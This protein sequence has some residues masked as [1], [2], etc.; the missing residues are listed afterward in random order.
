MTEQSG[1]KAMTEIRRL[2]LEAEAYTA[3]APEE[4]DFWAQERARAVAERGRQADPSACGTCKDRVAA[5]GQV[6]HDECAQRATLLPAP[7]APGYELIT[8]MTEDDVRALPARFHTP[9]FSELSTPNAW[10]CAVCWGDG[11]STAWPCPTAVKNGT[12]VFTPEHQAETGAKKQAAE[13]ERLRKERDGFRDQRNAVF[14][15]N[16]RLIGEVEA[17]GQ[18][19]IHAENQTRAVT[20]AA[21]EL[22]A[23]VAK[24]EALTPAKHQTCRKCGAGYEYGQPC[25]SCQFNALMA[26]ETGEGR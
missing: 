2:R 1:H 9:V 17:A 14:Q 8:G 21:E 4:D 6:E 13:L 10:V 7:D 26:A 20:R 18:A 22:R 25:S 15:T 23:R 16:Q 5:G 19:R 12:A 24:L 3:D 11:W